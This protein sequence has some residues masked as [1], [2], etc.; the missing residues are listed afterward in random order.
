MLRLPI[1]GAFFGNFAYFRG[2][3]KHLAFHAS[4]FIDDIA[5][6]AGDEFLA[7]S[8]V[9]EA[10]VSQLLPVR[11]ELDFLG[12]EEAVDVLCKWAAERCEKL[13]DGLDTYTYS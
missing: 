10:G 12:T 9:R 13:L 1:F 5:E 2:V 6:I 8:G 7:A 3:V 11:T 4:Q